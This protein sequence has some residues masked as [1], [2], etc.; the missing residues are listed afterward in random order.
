MGARSTDRSTPDLPENLSPEEG[1][2]LSEVWALAGSSEPI[3]SP[4]EEE[5]EEALRALHACRTA[6]AQR[7]ARSLPPER[8]NGR[9]RE[10]DRTRAHR[11]GRAGTDD[12]SRRSRLLARLRK[13]GKRTAA[14]TATAVL[15]LIVAVAGVFW[16]VRPIEKVAPP[17]ERRTVTLPDGSTAELNSGSQIRFRNHFFGAREVML[18]GE[19]FFDVAD[20]EAPFI[21]ET[22][23]AEAHAVGTRF[24]VRAWPEEPERATRVA[25]VAGRVLLVPEGERAQAVRMTPGEAWIVEAASGAAS[26]QVERAPVSVQ[27]ATAWRR[28]ELIFKNARLGAVL[29]DIERRFGKALHVETDSL[30]Q[31]RISLAIRQ[32][33][34]AEAVVRDVAL[35]LGLRYRDTAQGFEIH[36]PEP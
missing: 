9:T 18:E 19:A 7:E 20:R 11:A 27:E 32:P 22:F 26:P 29:G 8:S 10:L 15:L 24:G 14:A 5:T 3:R 6:P 28:G 1:E 23:N 30:R 17:G 2:R 13:G 35:A 36:A 31:R 4:S 21:V 34:G 33:V 12:T 16:W 25:L